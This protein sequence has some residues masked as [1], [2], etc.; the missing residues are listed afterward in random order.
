MVRFTLFAAC[1]VAGCEYTYPG[2]VPVDAPGD[3]AGDAEVPDIDAMPGRWS[4]PEALLVNDGNAFERAAS[5]SP[6]G[7]ELYFEAPQAAGSFA[8][9]IFYVSR[10]A[11][12]LE[13]SAARTAVG[14]LNSAETEGGANV[15]ADGLE[16]HF[17]RG[18]EVY[19]SRRA[20]PG[21]AWGPPT[22]TGLIGG[23]ANILAD[24]MVMYYRATGA[25]CPVDLCRMR[26]T[27]TGPQAPW[28][29]PVLE[30]IN[31]GGTYQFVDLSGDGLRAL[32][33]APMSGAVAP[34]A[35]ATRATRTAPW[36]PAEPITELAIYTAIVSA[37]WSWDEREMYLGYFTGASDLYVSHLR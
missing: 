32:L 3:T 5:A 23:S 20:T 35:I 8:G 19:V 28:G 12:S 1:L 2:D 31:D 36:G 11:T 29:D 6:S 9:D 17:N 7:L 21:A 10:T 18:G 14:A 4:A 37:T 24:G 25:S 30:A 26:V 22:G 33:S 34:V 13:W 15:S 27:R 16:L